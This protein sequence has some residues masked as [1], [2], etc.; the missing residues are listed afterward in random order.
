MDEWMVPLYD[1][2]Q[3]AE[4]KYPGEGRLLSAELEANSPW[5]AKEDPSI[6]LAWLQ[7]CHHQNHVKP[8][9]TTTVTLFF[10]TE[11]EKMT[12][13][14]EEKHTVGKVFIVGLVIEGNKFDPRNEMTTL[15]MVAS[16]V[17]TNPMLNAVLVGSNVEAV[18]TPAAEA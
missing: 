8:Y 1:F 9:H 7:L 4:A 12:W 5:L 10:A 6:Q 17:T 14:E 18:R 2:I 16:S 13:L 11:P 15:A 3:R